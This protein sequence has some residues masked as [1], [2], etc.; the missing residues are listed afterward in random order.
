[1]QR[2][3]R[4]LQRLAQAAADDPD[5]P[6]AEL[7]LLDEGE[8][9]QI[10]V[11]WNGD[12][13]DFA[14][15]RCF[16]QM[17]ESQAAQTPDSAAVNWGGQSLSY[18]Q[19]DRRA[20]RLA[21]HLR[22]LGV[23]PELRAGIFL[24]RSL[25][26]VVGLLGIHKA[27]GAYVPL[28]PSY[29]KQRLEYML[30]D[31]QAPLLLT[32]E[33]LLSRLPECSARPLCL[34]REDWGASPVPAGEAGVGVWP[35]SLAYVI[36][37]SGSTGRPKGVEVSH[38]ALSHYLNWCAQAYF[39]APGLGVPVHSSL[40]FDL[41]VTALMS[42][43]AVGECLALMPEEEALETLLKRFG[44]RD[45]FTLLKLTPSHLRLL[46]EAGSPLDP[47]AGVMIVGG[48]GLTG[49][50]LESLRRCT[51]ETRVWNEYGPTEATVGCCVYEFELGDAPEGSVPIGRPI[52][53]MSIYLIG[54]RFQP[55]PL[56]VAGELCIAGAG[57]ARGYLGAPQLSAL[58]FVP[59]P[60]SAQPG[61]RTYRTGDLARRRPDGVIE[62]LGRIDHQ[63]KIRGFRV[64]LGEIEASLEEH[65]DVL[66]AAVVE[67][68]GQ[69][70]G[71]VVG[72][73]GEE[74]R[75]RRGRG[76]RTQ[77]DA[78]KSSPRTL[79]LLSAPSAVQSPDLRRYLEAR[80]PE[81]MLPSLFV[82]L[83]E[84]PL[85]PNGKL[86]R[87]ALAEAAS[88]H[89]GPESAAPRTPTEE[90]LAGIWA[91]LLGL[92]RVGPCD[93][94]FERGGHSLLATQ[95]V[96]RIRGAFS[97]EL[98]L[99]RLFEA[100]RLGQ[101]A[102]RIDEACLAGEKSLAPPL[103]RQS[104]RD[105]PPLSFAQQRM[106]FL[107]QLEP[108]S[109]LYNVPLSV[110]LKGRLNLPALE[111]AL[112]RIRQRH[113]VLRSSFPTVGGRPRLQVIEP[114]RFS[115]AVVDLTQAEG[116]Q[117]EH[118]LAHLVRR[119]AQRPFNLATGPLLRAFL[120]RLGESEQALLATMHHIVSDAWSTQV[121]VRELTSLYQAFASGRPSP[122]KELP[123]QY[124]DFA[125]WQRRWL[126]GAALQEQIDSWKQNLQGAP[127]LQ[128]PTDHPRP[129]VPSQQGAS[130]SFTLPA[131]LS[132][133]LKAV[134]LQSDST[135]FMTLMAAFQTLLC[136]YSG[137]Q[138]ISLGTLVANRNR[139]ETEGLIGFFVN[140]LV[141]R[142]DLSGGVTFLELL[143]RVRE[144][145]LQAYAH[146]D[147]PFEQVVDALQP[148]RSLSRTP[149]FQV[150]FSYQGL[151]M[152][153]LKMPGIEVEP[154]QLESPL[155]RFDLSLS[156]AQG[157]QGLTGSLAYTTDLFEACTIRRMARHLQTLL[158][159]IAASPEQPI[160]ALP[161]TEAAEKQQLL[162]E[163]SGNRVDWP[164]RPTLH[165]LFEAQAARAPERVAVAFEEQ[166]LTFLHLNRAANRLAGSL[167]A[168]GVR[169]E[170]LV[171]IC[172]ERSIELVSAALAVLKAGAAFLP[173]DPDDPAQRLAWIVQDA[174]VQGLITHSQL[175]DRAAAIEAGC[176]LL[177]LDQE[178]RAVS[179]QS[180]GNLELPVGTG[181]LAYAIFTS[182][183]TG[184]PKGTL[185]THQGICNHLLWMQELH[186]L[187]ERDHLL[188]KTPFS[189]D[190]SIRE[191]FWPL[192]AGARLSVARPGGHR[193]PGQMAEIIRSREITVLHFVPSMLRAFLSQHEIP[194]L[195]SLRQVTCS[196]E[197]LP[198]DLKN[199]FFQRLGDGIE[200]CNRYGP[201]EASI[202][203]T[204]SLCRPAGK[205]RRVSIGRPNAN[206][207]IY[208]LDR[209]LQPAPMGAV[210]QLHI[211]GA[212]LARG[213]LKRP[214]QTADAFIP[215]PFGPQPGARL[216][217]S[218]DLARYRWDGCIDFL[219]RAD[220]QVKLRGFR[221]ELEEI[222]AV[223]SQ[224]PV[225]KMASAIVHEDKPGDRRLVAYMALDP[226][227]AQLA[228]EDLDLPSQFRSF[229]KERLPAF[230]VPSRFVV[231]EEMPLTPAG[232]VDRKALPAPERLALEAE[233]K[234][235]PSN[236]AEA[237][238]AEI[239]SEVLGL[240]PIGVEDNF[241]ELGGDSI[242][243]IQIVAKANQAGLRL[244]ARQ[245]FEHQ[246]IA[247]LAAVAG[248]GREIAAEQGMVEGEVPLTAI[249]HRFFERGL[250]DAQHWNQS[251]LLEISP[252]LGK[253]GLLEQAV[254]RLQVHHD[255][256]RMRFVREGSWWRQFNA[257]MSGP[258]PFCRL[259]LSALKRAL[260]SR[261]LESA[262]AQLQA[263]LD[264]GSG[265]LLRVAHFGLEA[266]Q[267]GRLLIVIHHLA[268]DGVSWR[269]L[270]EDLQTL[271]RQLSLGQPVQLPPK[272]TSFQEWARRLNEYARS[273]AA[274]AEAAYWLGQ[275]SEAAA[276]PVDAPGA[277][278]EASVRRV[279]VALS[280]QETQALLQE[281]PQAYGTQI[282]DAL[283]TALVQAFSGWT[284]TKRL[285]VDL[286]GH[287]REAL[288]EEVD[289]SRTVGWFTSIFPVFLPLEQASGPGQALKAVKEKLRSI[290]H[291][292]LGF[293]VLRYLSQ[294]PSLSR[295]LS[296]LPPPQV[297]FN[298]LGQ[299][300][301]ALPQSTTFRLAPESGG[302]ARS[303]RALRNHLLDVSGSIAD[304]KLRIEWS[305]SRDLHS[306]STI[307]RLAQDYI[308]ALRDL[309][310][311][312]QSVSERA[313]TPSDFPEADISQ[314]ELDE[315]YAEYAS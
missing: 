80:L 40:S 297:S 51:P 156:I 251:V 82:R 209:Q 226:E 19:L 49:A 35:H 248:Q 270:V 296:E 65:P 195:N 93:N 107:D 11:E 197:A 131:E 311:H 310:E 60:F 186:R 281:A 193:D 163:W 192:L 275:H 216:Y 190:V 132:E 257:A 151:A 175:A 53:G 278:A 233:Q 202:G 78:E 150:M 287:G 69:L 1:M 52:P 13:A 46:Q 178:R 189:F 250:A 300:D 162:A 214:A 110:R 218:G 279:S 138:D 44:H 14:A 59:D 105:D 191:I 269:V 201:T 306:R 117:R 26:M 241:F 272:T 161:M 159:G 165:G 313:Y 220:L 3:L 299:F 62:F 4:H 149:L 292:G 122:L 25:E 36:Y 182:G 43:L 227:A 267:P 184:R 140:T 77:R 210:A 94:F 283:L 235:P 222:E 128:L 148:H 228:A 180:G 289:I 303:P 146:Q 211:G 55:V 204:S 152:P 73:E 121:L 196:G 231:L 145:A 21:I 301:Q 298:Y 16:H 236:P 179:A 173:I 158:Q 15:D 95:V 208:L 79:R 295:R 249:Q 97:V 111:A 41:T 246:T 134:S 54:G 33:R 66:Q 314:R 288:F 305:Y 240:E 282:N 265:P 185:I 183:S 169:P 98:P 219:G 76:G 56:G 83:Q 126:S 155:S 50:D 70:V 194:G 112:D 106:W 176:W 48:E 9:H 229:L 71:F 63:I 17:F 81:Y 136:R 139:A 144:V 42:P 90:L 96:S 243:S 309:I 57:L 294:D 274:K 130:R 89:A 247:E 37:T 8:R 91:D 47:Q 116:A 154:L 147:I 307:E 72:R 137:Q 34:D 276:L 12:R 245:A 102:R 255:A 177:Q 75:T 45:A 20:G 61:S 170:G 141:L 6:V 215:N 259:D 181:H 261:A 230:M 213:Y 304:G 58:R 74:G 315:L 119:E 212:A 264:L 2:L 28:D 133:S 31:C 256:L 286:E 268:V 135:L 103:E 277:N 164:G 167:K 221:I 252:G 188:L 127:T 258:S 23:E 232:K 7:Q 39:T 223:L 200:L 67:K 206:V 203:V 263:S 253:L 237:L 312:C 174:G 207:Q 166:Q 30:R 242:L 234:V 225:V 84:L 244:T 88:P 143:Q 260:R 123:I 160:W 290:P 308:Q 92:E 64:E 168:R 38:R 114:G 87:K 18:R 238:L 120:V 27:G 129:S 24:E 115:L 68:D 32:Q 284:G 187:E 280:P 153:E 262:A 142:T 266:G 124:A 85:T 99:R 239:W 171:G 205:E 291:R 108:Q 254:D 22:S 157:E 118:E 100:P 271:C 104:R 172:L 302:P 125:D 285:R 217:R 29:P 101:L 109:R 199:R 113:Q 5:L 273:E 86:D 293:G 10:L 198:A 224:H